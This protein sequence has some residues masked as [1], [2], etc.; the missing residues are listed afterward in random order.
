MKVHE[1]SAE[2]F[3]SHAIALL[4]AQQ[5]RQ[6]L[7]DAETSHRRNRRTLHVGAVPQRFRTV[8]IVIAI[9]AIFLCSGW[10][11]GQSTFGSV[12]GAVADAGAAAIPNAKIILHSTDENTDR[13]VSSDSS[14]VYLFENV[15]AGQY[16]IR[17]QHSGFADTE[18]D[19]ITLAARQDLRFALTLQIAAQAT[20]VQVTSSV[21]E[22][23]TENASIGDMKTGTTLAELPLNYRAQTT[24]PLA[25]L[26]TSANVQEDTSGNIAIAGATSNMTGFSVDGI[27]TVNVWTSGASLAAGAQGVNAYPSSEAISELKV[28]AFNNNAEF[29]QV[30]DVTFTTKGG[31]NEFH[32]SLYEYLQN[33]AFNAKAYDFALKTPERFNTFGGSLSGPLVVPHLYNGRDKT[34]FFFDYEGNRKRTSEAVQYDLPSVQDRMGNLSDIGGPVIPTAEINP[35]ATTLLND[36]YPLPNNNTLPGGLNYQ[37]LVPMPSSTN[38]FDGRIDQIISPKQQMFVRYNW[39]NMMVDVVN[40]LL[41]DDVD[42]EHDR[43]FLVSHNYEFTTNLLNEFRYGF[44]TSQLTPDFPIQ[45]EQALSQLGLLSQWPTIPSIHQNQGGFPSINFTQGT[46]FQPIGRDIVGPTNSSTYEMADNLTWTHGKHTIRGGFDIRWVR[47]QVVE[48]ETPS[49]DFGLI[50][51]Q[52]TFTGNSFGDLLMGLPN[53]TYFALTGPNDNAGGRQYGFYAQDEWQVNNRLT[54]NYGLRWELLPPFVDANGI[55]A[56]FDPATNAVIVNQK[57]YTSLGGPVPAFLESF[58]ACNAAPPGFSAPADAGYTPSSSLP[59]TNVVSNTQEGLPPGLRQTYMRN[60]DPRISFAYRPFGGDKTVVRGGGGI[61]T[62]TAL[63]QLQ[64]NNES[65]PQASVFTYTNQNPTTLLPTFQF[66]AVR[67]ASSGIVPGG[68]ELEQATDPH[69]RDAQSAQWNLT[70]EHDLTANIALRASYVGESSYR[71]NTTINL[72]QQMPSTVSPNPNL[73]P[74]PNWGTIFQTGNYGHEN[75]NALELQATQRMGHG[76]SYQA[77]YTWA[78]DLSDAQGDAPT[79]FQGETNYG[80]AVENRFDIRA[81]RGNV[82]GTRR[83][84]FML[85][86][87]YELPYGLGRHWSSKSGIVNGFL[88]GWNLS[89][90]TLLETG[91]YLT[92]TMSVNEDQTN[93]G[94]AAAGILVVRPDRIGNPIPAD[95]TRAAYF[96]INAFAPPPLNAGRVG[97]ASVGSLEGPGAVVVNGGLAKVQHIHGNLN[98]RF[99]AT[100]TNVLNRTNFAPP[101]T[102]ISNPSSFGALTTA[103]SAES[104]GNRTGQVALRLDF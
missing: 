38:G 13:V 76:L 58:N 88:G 49:D 50:T 97:N 19:G 46:N 55:Q 22:I 39:K 34:F 104:A 23:N 92:P 62:V 103:E 28:N 33:D 6:W 96:N 72:N 84:R 8:G 9:L 11:F 12:R 71:V 37:A 63:G 70:V 94:P 67:P 4:R 16:T 65:N 69:Y 73:I 78:H 1:T 56:N 17:G 24:S 3:H 83:Q 35:T 89:T 79:A 54:I 61:Y 93:T 90:I 43:S 101:A 59:C 2:E 68:G 99:E 60:F 25:A 27:S 64:N 30:A 10:C 14:G 52:S 51:F 40:P 45:G 53:T 47:F 31:T 87:T 81:N 82:E 66:P 36:Y 5:T 85:T 80:L 32:G 75:Y 18:L 74:F 95:R 20:T 86:G 91:P 48:I 21:A 77:N 7:L 29:S 42:S 100:F 98:L 41:P 57:L 44:S 102:D 15:P 26:A